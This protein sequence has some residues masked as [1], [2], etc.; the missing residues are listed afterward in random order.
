MAK[1]E[2]NSQ[3]TSV[4]NRVKW[5]ALQA[6]VCSPQANPFIFR[7]YIGV[8]QDSIYNNH[9]DPIFFCLFNGRQIPKTLTNRLSFDIFA[10]RVWE[11]LGAFFVWNLAGQPTPAPLT[12]P[13]PP[14]N[15]ALLRVSSPL[16]SLNKIVKFHRIPFIKINMLVNP[17]SSPRFWQPPIH[18]SQELIKE[19]LTTLIP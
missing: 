17:L 1:D 3:S 13:P 15:K 12:Y 7:P 9:R 18:S 6:G 14:R 19:L 11:H 5:G 2:K 8:L 4:R 10:F 16:V